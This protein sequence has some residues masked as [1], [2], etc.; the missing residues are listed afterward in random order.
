MAEES[1]QELDP[2]AHEMRYDFRRTVPQ[3]LTNRFLALLVE[4]TEPQSHRVLPDGRIEEVPVGERRPALRMIESPLDRDR[5][6]VDKLERE[7]VTVLLRDLFRP[8]VKSTAEF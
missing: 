7:L 8:A 2:R 4:K 1:K 5:E 3:D 6:T